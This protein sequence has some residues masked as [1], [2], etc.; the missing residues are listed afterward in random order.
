MCWSDYLCPWC[1]VGQARSAQME[2]LG[3]TVVHRPFELHPEI[4]PAGRPVRPDGRL[5]P[6]FARVEAECEAAGL[7]WRAPTRMPNTRRAL[8]AAEWV[9]VHH[10]E[11]AAALHAALFHAHFAAGRALDDPAVIDELVAESGAPVDAVRAAVTDGQASQLVDASMHEARAAGVSSTPTWVLHDGFTIPGALDAATVHRWVSK[12]VA[13]AAA[14]GP[15][16]R[17]S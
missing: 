8:E 12:V 7:P 11:A 4:P 14:G 3:L 15:S 6:T 10:A 16:S 13:R 5:A 9:R 17:P 2:E 1:Y